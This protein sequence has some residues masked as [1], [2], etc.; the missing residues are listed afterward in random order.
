MFERR[1]EFPIRFLF[2]HYPIRGQEHGV[3]K[4]FAERKNRFLEREREL[5]WHHQYERVKDPSHSF[6]V[7]P[8]ELRAFDLDQARLELMLRNE[9]TEA[10]DERA[11]RAEER[12]LALEGEAELTRAQLEEP[13]EQLEKETVA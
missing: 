4:V 10:A 11:S 12:I 13:D 5:G 6:L 3:Q 1:R 2:R 9:V 8:A 7:D